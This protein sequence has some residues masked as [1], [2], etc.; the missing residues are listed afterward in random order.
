MSRAT[1]DTDWRSSYF[2]SADFQ[3]ELYLVSKMLGI[4]YSTPRYLQLPTY[5]LYLL[6]TCECILDTT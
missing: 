3:Y 6:S 1:V 5:I 2:L 4:Y